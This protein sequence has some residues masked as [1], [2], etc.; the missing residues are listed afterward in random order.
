ME[1]DNSK[2]FI[3][4]ADSFNKDKNNYNKNIEL[5][6][7]IKIQE[8]DN[9]YS[10]L[11]NEINLLF[12]NGNSYDSQKINNKILK[13]M[14]G[15][16]NDNIAVKPI[17]NAVIANK[18]RFKISNELLNKIINIS[19][20]NNYYDIMF[21]LY[22]DDKYQNNGK[23][24]ED[25]PKYLINIFQTEIKETIFDIDRF[26]KFINQLIFNI[27]IDN[28]TK[29]N[30]TMYIVETIYNNKNIDNVAK[31]RM[32]NMIMYNI[33]NTFYVGCSVLTYTFD[34]AINEKMDILFFCLFEKYCNMVGILS[35]CSKIKKYYD[36]NYFGYLK[37]K[38]DYDEKRP[39]YSLMSDFLEKNNNEELLKIINEFDEN[40]KLK[41]SV[42]KRNIFVTFVNACIDTKKINELITLFGYNF[43][44]D[45]PDLGLFSLNK[46]IV[47]NGLN[48][49]KV[50]RVLISFREK[51]VKAFSDIKK[52][53]VYDLKTCF[54]SMKGYKSYS[55]IMNNVLIAEK[56]Y[57]FDL[58]KS[59]DVDDVLI[60]T[61]LHTMQIDDK[62]ELLSSLKINVFDGNKK[63]SLKNITLE[64]IINFVSEGDF[65]T[66]LSKALFENLRKIDNNFDKINKSFDEIN[67]K[68][69]VVEI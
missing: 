21:Y 19:A 64:D 55:E 58:R 7:T 45:N 28:I 37:F 23:I 22:V 26:N 32:L 38:I 10:Y 24:F 9:N 18:N 1:N 44:V 51:A 54:M 30:L 66:K 50:G 60:D 49:M 52:M 12:E 3:S 14:K 69:T 46:Y 11:F 68:D 15:A 6:T 36:S 35:N 61:I 59:K 40:I 56:V 5:F 43:Y 20:E 39:L 31:E 33:A 63:L 17:L 8:T 67:N 13:I 29:N 34:I 62:E 4:F 65:G 2:S 25:A 57:N 48:T 42:I 27:N 53:K 47:D 16:L 41:D